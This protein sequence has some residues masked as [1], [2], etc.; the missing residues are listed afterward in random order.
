MKIH[1]VTIAGFGPYKGREVV[2]FE[3]FAD[4]GLFVITGKT[5]AGKS[6]ILDA[7]T[8]ALF[9]DVPRYGNVTDDSVRSKYLTDSSDETRVDL[10]FS[11]GERRYRVSRIPSYTKQGNKNASL[12]WAELAEITV[13]GEVVI[14]SRQLTKVSA[15]IDEIVRLNA[16]QFKQVVLLAQGEFQRFLVA[17]SDTRRELLRKLF[18]TGRFQRYGED[19]DGQSKAL[20][21]A[22]EHTG[23][24]ITAHIASLAHEVGQE[25]PT[26][27]DATQGA[28]VVAWAEPLLIT[29][30]GMLA[31]AD[32]RAAATTRTLDDAAAA[33]STATSIAERQKRRD[34]ALAKKAALAAEQPEIDA[35]TKALKAAQKADLAW[36]AVTIDREATQSREFAATT[37]SHAETAFGLLLPKDAT[38]P[39]ALTALANAHTGLAATLAEAAT[40]E[41]GIETLRTQAEQASAVVASAR[42]T[43]AEHGRELDALK[44]SVPVLTEK[45]VQATKSADN[46]AAADKL[47]GALSTQ[48]EAATR[49]EATQGTLTAAH[50]AEIAARESAATA[51]TAVT[52]LKKQQ[53]GEYAGRLAEA[54]VD[55]E[56][57]AVCGSPNHP[58]PAALGDGGVTDEQIIGAEAAEKKSTTKATTA[59][60][61]VTQLKTLLE[62]ELTASQAVSTA[63]LATQLA[64]AEQRVTTARAAK[65]TLTELLAQ[66][67]SLEA[68]TSAK[69]EELSVAKDAL[70]NATTAST[71]AES[72]L[73]AESTALQSARGSFATVAE[74]LA[75]IRAELAATTELMDARA[76]LDRATTATT[77]A[78]AR[79][80]TALTK[81]GFADAAQVERAVVAAP[82][83]AALESRIRKHEQQAATVAE[84]LADDALKSL[85]AKP[86][87]LAGPAETHRLAQG[88][89]TL[90]VR[91]QGE[92][93]K[94][95]S[96]I[97]NLVGAI[98][99]ALASAGTTQRDY[100]IVFRLAETVKGQGPNTKKMS[101][102]TFALA[103]DLEEI[104]TQANVLLRTMTNGRYELLYSDELTKGRGKSG[105]ALEVN[106]AYND[107]RRPPESLSGGEKFQASLA[108][109]LGL[110]EVVTS[111]NG[112]VRLDTLFID[113][114][115]GALDE[116]TLAE[117][118][119]TID[120]LREGGRTVGLISHVDQ[121]KERIAN[122]L[123]VRV[124][125]GGWS[126]LA[127]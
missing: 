88:T 62:A 86:V 84:T 41:V 83:Q 91:G 36:S 16:D 70:A 68:E 46:F 123:N 95:C 120:S 50:A 17:N 67:E 59:A 114:G 55:G 98:T 27:F 69:A 21:A 60:T 74:R 77:E 115:F 47:H 61:R 40:R 119:D 92:A 124:S 96:S 26:S 100:D 66:R 75:R 38:E 54:L 6:S 108:L 103:A 73:A 117:V 9:G 97:K 99:T 116:E 48:F 64:E 94:S 25:I 126:T 79:L 107:E 112:G 14:E 110:A 35:A 125:P 28:A 12:Q 80:A 43:L 49:A 51:H 33:L 18:N 37:H 65:L 5:G 58:S 76:T 82:E 45:I 1:R 34:T 72:R 11:Q 111:R 109:A 93:S 121:V 2:D 3:A 106:D 19:L 31:E 89:N 101:L 53:Y 15:Q 85:P 42:E 4:D 122:H 71:L 39:V 63:E 78:A 32:A 7:V 56:A 20:R 30:Q 90:A 8:F 104:V 118:L 113:E 127:P 13:A 44:K 10:E 57:C 24:T 29:Q 81:H 22:L 87:D 102:E 105:L 52:T 23:T